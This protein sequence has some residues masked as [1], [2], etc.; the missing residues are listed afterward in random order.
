VT[1]NAPQL[2]LFT[3][4]NTFTL[5]EELRRWKEAFLFKHGEAN[6]QLFTEETLEW[7][8]FCNEAKSAPFLSDKRLL[9][10]EGIPTIAKEDLE[11][12]LKE[13]HEGT[14][15]LFVDAAPDKR[16]S[17]VKFLLKEATV[18]LFSPLSR[19]KLLPWVSA[20]GK[21]YGITLERE[22]ADF[23]IRFIGTD[24]WVLKQECLKVFAYS[25]PN[26]PRIPDVQKV[27]LPSTTHAIWTLNELIGKGKTEEAALFGS[28]L[29]ESGEDPFSL[30][31]LLLY[32][33]RNIATLWIHAQEKNLPA[34]ALARETGV[35]FLSVQSLLPLVRSL[36]KEQVST[37][38]KN[39]VAADKALKSGEMKATAQNSIELIA[40]LERQILG[41]KT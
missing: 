1:P 20:L 14:V 12:L 4:E 6:L 10:I 41:L 8:S 24:Q 5:A 19:E 35:N 18:K 21:D 26:A 2:Y 28:A 32:I 17:I 3:G 27:C 39:A 38:V 29:W 22:V 36:S 13:M 16:K 25:A 33:V 34:A 15:I 40:M 31:N 9:I 30:W 37:I 23:M 7:I 11:S